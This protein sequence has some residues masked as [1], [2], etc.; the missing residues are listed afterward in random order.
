MC[1]GLGIATSCFRLVEGG[2]PVGES[3]GVPSGAVRCSGR[4]T[5][6][7][8]SAKLLSQQKD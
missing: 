6:R 7:G 3:L 5:G 8:A 4:R 1:T 2:A